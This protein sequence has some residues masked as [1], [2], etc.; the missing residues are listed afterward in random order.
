[1]TLI[2]FLNLTRDFFMSTTIPHPEMLTRD[3][4]AE[5]IGSRPQT[6]AVWAITGR[7]N[8][9]MVKV[10]RSVRYR[11]SDIDAWLERRTV[12]EQQ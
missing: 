8:L 3:Q 9:P 5:Y 4:A 11:R 10:G 2:V 6:L 7:Y 12:G 1:L